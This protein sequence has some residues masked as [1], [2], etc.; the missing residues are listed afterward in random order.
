[1]KKTIIA[2]AASVALAAMPVVGVFASTAIQDKITVTVSETCAFSRTAGAGEYQ[3]SLLGGSVAENF[4]GS[5]FEV[6]C[7]T[8]AG[9]TQDVNVTAEFQDLSDGAGNSIPYAAVAPTADTSSW[10]AMKS[11]AT[12]GSSAIAATNGMLIDAEAT[13][14][15]DVFT[16]NVKYSVGVADD[17]EAGTYTGYAT[18][19]LVEN[20]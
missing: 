5:T 12:A 13:E 15:N 6:I 4:G 3:A 1:M 9:E 10:V 18:Y 16:A 11:T 2:G 14:D 19:T 20:N 17:Q 8:S 7:N